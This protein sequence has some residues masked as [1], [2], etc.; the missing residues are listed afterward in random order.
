MGCDLCL[1]K[2]NYNSTEKKIIKNDEAQKPIMF[3]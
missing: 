2:L 3:S 1:Q